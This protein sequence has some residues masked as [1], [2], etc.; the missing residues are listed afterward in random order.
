VREPEELAQGYIPTAQNLPLTA[1]LRGAWRMNEVEFEEKFGFAK[2]QKDQEVIV[3]CKKGKR[4]SLACDWANK[5]GYT[6]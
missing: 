2:P 6:K 5:N 4:A 3:Y 1:I